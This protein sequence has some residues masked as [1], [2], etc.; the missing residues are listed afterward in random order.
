MKSVWVK[1]LSRQPLLY[2][3]TMVF[4]FCVARHASQLN[5]FIVVPARVKVAYSVGD[6]TVSSGNAVLGFFLLPF[7]FIHL[8][9]SLCH[10]PGVVPGICQIASY[11]S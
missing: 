9:M 8:F 2:I 4:C 7:F 6:L 1:W 5:G 11:Y 3:P 10:V